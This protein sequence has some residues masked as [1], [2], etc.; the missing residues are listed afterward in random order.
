ME[1]T[2][3]SSV[4]YLKKKSSRPFPKLMH[5]NCGKIVYFSGSGIGILLYNS[6]YKSLEWDFSDAWDMDVFFDFEGSITLSN[7]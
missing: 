1:K 5:S 4:K 7:D 6:T 2:M 3:Q